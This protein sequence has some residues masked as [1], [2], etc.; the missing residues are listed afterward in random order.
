MVQVGS[1]SGHEVPAG[2]EA[3][4]ARRRKPDLTPEEA[5]IWRLAKLFDLRSFI[6]ALMLSAKPQ[7]DDDLLGSPVSVDL[8]DHSHTIKA[9]TRRDGETTSAKQLSQTAEQGSLTSLLALGQEV[10]PLAITA[11][12]RATTTFI[13]SLSPPL[14]S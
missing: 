5:K 2:A 4:P 7:F 6:G 11:A 13:D 14:L 12:D 1:A 8:A 10:A 9:I 3:G